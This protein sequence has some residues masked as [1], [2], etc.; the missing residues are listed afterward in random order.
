MA[1]KYNKCNKRV[2]L[3]KR[4]IMPH[5]HTGG[6]ERVNGEVRGLVKNH[7]KFSENSV[8]GPGP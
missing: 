4:T 8:L 7:V 2:H 5:V 1:D 3:T 6:L